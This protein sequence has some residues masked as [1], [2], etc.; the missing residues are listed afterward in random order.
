MKGV[1][2]LGDVTT[3]GGRVITASAK[4]TVHGKSV[5][6][7]GD[8]VSCPI[9]GHGISA[10]LDGSTTF[11]HEGKAIAVHGSRCGCGCQVLSSTDKMQTD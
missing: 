4:M 9:K 3:N 7:V 11:I 1:I 8:L 10:I 6:L 5:A 2:L